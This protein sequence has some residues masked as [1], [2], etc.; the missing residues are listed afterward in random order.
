MIMHEGVGKVRQGEM[1]MKQGKKVCHTREEP[2]VVVVPVVVVVVG[3]VGV[4][5]GDFLAEGNN[6]GDLVAEEATAGRGGGGGLFNLWSR[7]QW[8]WL[9]R[10]MKTR[11]L[12]K[13]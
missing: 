12:K 6:F 5:D 1:S 9:L 11:K 4:V 8:G 13:R 2:L 3:V 10:R 7:N